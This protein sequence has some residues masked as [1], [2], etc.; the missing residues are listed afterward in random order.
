MGME[1]A[2]GDGRGPEALHVLA[3]E[4]RRLEEQQEAVLALAEQW[5]TR[6]QTVVDRFHQMMS[7]GKQ[8]LFEAESALKREQGRA[9]Q[10]RAAL[11]AK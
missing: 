2:P 6:A 5:I 11:E 7:P 4:V 8:A 3:D 1:F 10:I 9:D